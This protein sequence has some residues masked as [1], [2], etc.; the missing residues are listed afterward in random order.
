MFLKTVEMAQEL[1]WADGLREGMKLYKYGL[2][3][4]ADNPPA[5]RAIMKYALRNAN[6]QSKLTAKE[7]CLYRTS[8][9]GR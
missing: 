2:G 8:N 3:I 7:I 6:K 9:V 4:Q 1:G 5:Y